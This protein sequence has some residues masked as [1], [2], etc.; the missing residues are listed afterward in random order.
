MIFAIDF[1]GTI[2]EHE[3]PKIG[4]LKINSKEV[5]NKLSN[6]GH[7]IVIWTCRYLKEDLEAMRFFLSDNNIYYHGINCNIGFQSFQP[8]PKIYADFYIDDRDISLIN[9]GIDWFEIE[10]NLIENGI[11]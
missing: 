1:D 2:V 9:K 7:Q 10:K 11:L 6:K 4:K 5:I 3:Y 8:E